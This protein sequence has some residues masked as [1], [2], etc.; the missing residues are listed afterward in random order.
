MNAEN[1][2]KKT[3]LL[4]FFSKNPRISVQKKVSGSQKVIS[5]LII[6]PKRIQP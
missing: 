4:M 5:F 2:D 3:P 6:Q 1:A